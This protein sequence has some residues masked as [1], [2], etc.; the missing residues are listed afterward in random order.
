MQT[1]WLWGQVA[2]GAV[3]VAEEDVDAGAGEAEKE[4]SR[5]VRRL[6]T[7]GKVSLHLRGIPQPE[8]VLEVIDD[9]RC[10]CD[11]ALAIVA[12][13]SDEALNIVFLPRQAQFTPKITGCTTMRGVRPS[14]KARQR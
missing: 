6:R 12:E 8:E 3:E 14:S 13:S 10:R 1:S 2:T 11:R 9:L 7:G 5:F 4:A